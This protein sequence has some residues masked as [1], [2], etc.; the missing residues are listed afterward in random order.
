M[1]F[2]YGGRTDSVSFKHLKIK[3]MLERIQKALQEGKV[4]F[5]FKK[6]DGTVRNAYGTLHPSLLPVRDSVEGSTSRPVNPGVQVY[7]DL[8]AGS[9]RSF[10]KEN[11]VSV[12][13]VEP[14]GVV[15]EAENVDP[16]GELNNTTVEGVSN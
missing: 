13:V 8:D 14:Y 5:S 11:L 10:K 2:A 9:F 7:Y 3:V 15:P 12:D 6:V 1:S 16:K 4:H